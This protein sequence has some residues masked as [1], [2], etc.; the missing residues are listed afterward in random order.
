M[1]RQLLQVDFVPESVKRICIC[2]QNLDPKELHIRGCSS[3][4][5][6]QRHQNTGYL[7]GQFFTSIG[8]RPIS[9]ELVISNFQGLQLAIKDIQT[10]LGE[11]FPVSNSTIAN[12]SSSNLEEISAVSIS[13][14]AHHNS[15][16]GTSLD[17]YD[18]SSHISSNN[19]VSSSSS[20]L[21]ANKIECLNQNNNKNRP[22]PSA[23]FTSFNPNPSVKVKSIVNPLSAHKS[24]A[25]NRVDMLIE[26]INLFLDLCIVNNSLAADSE[27]LRKFESKHEDKN[28]L[29]LE[30]VRQLS[31]DYFAPI[32]STDGSASPRTRSF[33]L[34]I[35]N[36]HLEKLEAEDRRI[37]LKNGSLLNHFFNLICFQINKDNAHQ[38]LLLTPK[39]FLSPKSQQLLNTELSDTERLSHFRVAQSTHISS[40]Q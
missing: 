33:F 24:T 25:G 16:V 18:S 39:L 12:V 40:Q 23:P 38:A 32:F 8:M 22:N 2:N 31:C 28:R 21:D 35:Y 26:D 14:Y 37:K 27:Y 9:G 4:G 30:K 29:H 7:L 13:Q 6:K 36:K 17:G 20:R 11:S 3:C 5:I 19:T 10:L 15:H 34:Q 1:M